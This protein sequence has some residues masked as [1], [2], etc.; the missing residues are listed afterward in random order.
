MWL[1]AS[2]AHWLAPLLLKLISFY[3]K[4]YV[5][6]WEGFQWRNLKFLNPLGIAGGVDKSGF[7]VSDWWKFG[8]G[9]VEV[10]TVTPQPQAPNSPPYI[11]RDI[12]N[13]TL[14]NRL[15]FPNRG[16]KVVKKRL[17]RLK[18]PYLTPVF[19][20]IGK[21]RQTPE[22]LAHRDYVLL[23][24]AFYG[25]VDGFVINISSPNTES[26]RRLLSPQKLRAFLRPI[27]DAK[28]NLGETCHLLLKLSPDM[29][30]SDVLQVIDIG[31]ELHLDGFVLT[32]S[33]L[34]RPQTCWYPSAGGISGAFLGKKS[35]EFLKLAHSHLI[36]KVGKDKR[37]DY[38]LVSV[39]GVIKV[40][41][42]FERLRNGADL[43]QCYTALVFEGPYFF[44]NVQ[45]MRAALT[46]S[47]S[48]S[49]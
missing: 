28:R 26:L 40:Q 30:S 4:P 25:L 2:T 24:Q 13:K 10:G 1:P 47:T 19:L 35:L 11:M 31:I 29:T 44:K 37:K 36:S 20:N 15:G 22:D 5:E 42:V 3:R 39:G 8:V 7:N 14:W 49:V 38:L 27:V 6:Q 46:K 32:N 48:H 18:K 16:H 43:V 41:D 34:A 17:L 45:K 12:A 23:I 21:N 9:F 33:T